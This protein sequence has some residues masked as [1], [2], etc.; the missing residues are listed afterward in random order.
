M[1][2]LLGATLDVTLRNWT[3]PCARTVLRFYRHS[4]WTGTKM[5]GR[6]AVKG[7]QLAGKHAVPAVRQGF[8]MAAHF[9]D[10]LK[11]AGK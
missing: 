5:G 11:R 7:C 9:V 6:L 2:V 4:A 10:E 8:G 3:F 1:P